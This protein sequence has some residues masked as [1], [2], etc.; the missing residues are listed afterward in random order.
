MKII[1]QIDGG[2]GKSVM[3]TAVCRVVC[4]NV[5]SQARRLQET[6]PSE[7]LGLVLHFFKMPHFV[8]I[9]ISRYGALVLV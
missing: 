4:I 1:F 7:T 5:V 3:A 9:S 2:I 8:K 6:R